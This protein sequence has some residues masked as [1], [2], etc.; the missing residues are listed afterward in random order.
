MPP[1]I[2]TLIENACHLFQSLGH[3]DRMEFRIY[4]SSSTIKATCNVAP[5]LNEWSLLTGTY[6]GNSADIYLNG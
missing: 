5:S 6:N 3:A 1:L 4:R 2:F